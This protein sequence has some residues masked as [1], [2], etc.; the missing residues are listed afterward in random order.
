MATVLIVP[1]WQDS[2]PEHWQSL[3]ER[4]YPEWRRVRDLDWDEPT[5]EVWVAGL[6]SAIREIGMPVVLVCHSLG[7]IAAVEWATGSD[8]NRVSAALLVAPPDLA[9]PDT[10][11]AI[12][13]FAPWRGNRLPFPSL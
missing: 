3:W 12:R 6:D 2:G 1:G 10:P 11:A 5:R 7:C 9:Q 4:A 13:D 8:A